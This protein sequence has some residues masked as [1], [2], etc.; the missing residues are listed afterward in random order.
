MAAI[1][2]QH[3]TLLKGQNFTINS[4][5]VV[6]VFGNK[7]VESAVKHQSTNHMNV[8]SNIVAGVNGA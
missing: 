5:V 7:D 8:A 6:A 2:K 1:L 4:F 3:W